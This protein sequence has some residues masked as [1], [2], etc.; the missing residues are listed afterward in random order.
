MCT[1]RF[2]NRSFFPLACKQHKAE[3]PL[4]IIFCFI[5]QLVISPNDQR[6][7]SPVLQRSAIDGNF[8]RITQAFYRLLPGMITQL[9]HQ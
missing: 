1:S 5:Q 7:L 4:H 9:A 8:C 2:R 3:A 6:R